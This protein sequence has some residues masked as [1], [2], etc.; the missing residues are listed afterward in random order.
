MSFAELKTR[1][2]RLRPAQRAKLVNVL[3]RTLD[4][5][6]EEPLTM[7][8]LDRRAEDLRSGRVKGIPAKE[9][10]ASARAHLRA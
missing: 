8:E 1:A 3:I 4:K 9:M 7:E 5:D 6:E 10:V 2:L